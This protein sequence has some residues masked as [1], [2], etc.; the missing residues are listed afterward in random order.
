MKIDKDRCTGREAGGH[1]DRPL[2]PSPCYCQQPPPPRSLPLHFT[3]VAL[4]SNSVF[5]RRY[6]SRRGLITAASASTDLQEKTGGINVMMSEA[7][8]RA[9]KKTSS[10]RGKQ[11][12]RGGRMVLVAP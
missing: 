3:L 7:R 5:D 11:D 1:D 8:C 2:S 6:I 9:V 12:G 10:L 4:G